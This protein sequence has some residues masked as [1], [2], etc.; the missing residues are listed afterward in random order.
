MGLM[1][2]SDWAAMQADLQAVRDDNAV[3]I[4]IRR[5]ATTLA[6]QTVRVAGQQT[7]RIATSD[8]GEQS[9]GEV[10]VLGLPTLN[11]QVADRFTVG[12]ILYEVVYVH[13]NRRA[14]T[15]ARAKA[16]E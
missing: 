1:G 14:K 2:S 11:I 6:S 9:A 3:S 5:G 7:G 8:G 15:Q 10:T 16:V 12:G 13:P 4:T